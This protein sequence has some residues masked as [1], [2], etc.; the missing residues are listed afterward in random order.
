MHVLARAFRGDDLDSFVVPDVA[1]GLH[2]HRCAGVAHHDDV[3]YSADLGD[4]GIGVGLERHFTPATHPFVGGDHDGRFAVRDATGER[5]GREAA[6]HDGMDSANA[7]TGEDGVDRLRDHGQVDRHPVALLDL[8]VAQDVGKR[9]DLVVQLLIGDVLRLRGIIALPD[10]RGLVRAFR[11]MAVYT[12]V[13]R[14]QDAILEPF[15]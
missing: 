5:F 1:H 3:I 9:A 4:R 7:R 11:Q 8:A 2:V 10:D 14:I 12:V 13:G 6:E 15:D